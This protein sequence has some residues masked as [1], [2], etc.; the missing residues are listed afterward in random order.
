L[1]S[2][3]VCQ[4]LALKLAGRLREEEK[5]SPNAFARDTKT[6]LLILD[7]RE[8][9][10]T[11]L[12]NQWTYQAMLHE[13]IGIHN[14]RVDLKKDKEFL[15]KHEGDTEFVISSNQDRFFAEHMY[16]NFGEL[17]DSI[18]KFIDEYTSSKKQNEKKIESLD[19][20]QKILDSLPELTRQSG[21][22]NKHVTLSQEIS[23]LVRERN[24]IDVSRVEQEIS[25]KENRSDHFKMV[26]DIL[27]KQY[28]RLDKLKLVILYALRYEA[29]A[30]GIQ[31]LKDKLRTDPVLSDK[32]SLIDSVLR[33]AGKSQRSG[34]LFANRDLVNKWTNK[35][36][37]AFRDVPNVFTQ[38]QPYI[39][40][41]LD[42]INNK[43]LRENDYPVQGNNFKDKP[44]EIIIFIVGGA[45]F[46]EAKEVAELN[47]RGATILLGGTHVQNSKTFLAEMSSLKENPHEIKLELSSSPLKGKVGKDPN[48][49]QR[50][51]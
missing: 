28:E 36:K 14:N 42:M 37:Q 20:M 41:L 1:A 6:M 21:N 19:D 4:K 46:E 17:A 2:S 3:E 47:R 26:M 32:I 35:V 44:N 15:A 40:N 48:A 43:K 33:Y 23:K 29:D 38:H 51:E 16:E 50:F 39:L 22:L 11:P 25:C 31:K 24:L 8:D 45:T 18:K 12:L 49:F 13:L 34:D 27:E 9:P 7:R 5:E 10:V 30:Q